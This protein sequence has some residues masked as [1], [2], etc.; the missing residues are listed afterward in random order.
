MKSIL[1]VLVTL[2]IALQYKLWLGDGSVPH[3]LHLKQQVE[4]EAAENMRLQQRNKA[5]IAEVENLKRGNMALEE[6]ARADLG[7]V[8]QGEVFYQ[9]KDPVA[10]RKH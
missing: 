3:I 7:M 4:L 10:E 6:R 8:K 2:L 5:L 1:L 9:F